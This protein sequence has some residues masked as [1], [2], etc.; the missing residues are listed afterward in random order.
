VIKVCLRKLQSKHSVTQE[1]P[2]FV[3]ETKPSVTQEQNFSGIS[4]NAVE[5]LITYWVFSEEDR[6]EECSFLGGKTETEISDKVS[7][8]SAHSKNS[9]NERKP[10]RRS[11]V[12]HKKKSVGSRANLARMPVPKFVCE[13]ACASG[14]ASSA[15]DC[16]SWDP[17]SIV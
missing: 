13:V 4:S 15:D 17:R 8:S 11:L 10:Q 9:L 7:N 1:L 3:T 14:F 6:C 2:R 16:V 12:W 5:C